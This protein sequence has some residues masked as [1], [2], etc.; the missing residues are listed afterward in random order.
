MID[1]GIFIGRDATA[2]RGME[3]AKSLSR[4]KSLGVTHALAASFRA[5]HFDAAEGNQDTM[6]AVQNSS[7]RL[8]PLAAVSTAAFEAGRGQIAG[9]KDQGF[10]GVILAPCLSG[11]R[12]AGYALRSL[13]SESAEAGLPLQVVIA[14]QA[15]LAEVA[16]RSATT[17]GPILVRWNRGG[18]YAQLPDVIAVG[19]DCPNLLFDIGIATQ[20]GSIELL[21][22]HLGPE[23]LF[24]AS[25]LPRAFEA[26]PYFML[27]AARLSDNSRRLIGGAN[28]ARIYG[29]PAPAESG[30]SAMFEALRTRPKIDTHWHTSGWNL[31]EPRIDDA[32][33]RQEFDYFS[34]K[35]VISS[36]IRA[37]NDDLRAGNAETL[38]LIESDARVRGLV[39][40]DP[41][42]PEVSITEIE[43]YRTDPRF[44]GVKTIQ[45][46]YHLD[47]DA[48]GY[49]RI[50]EH[51]RSLLDWPVMAH[52]PGMKEAATR[53]P[54]LHFI[55]A[56]STWDYRDL[57]LLSNV[58]FD[59]ATSTPLRDESDI[60]GLIEVVGAG[61][62]L[63]ST[64]GQLINPAWTL[65]KLASLDL[66][67]DD[68]D[69]IFLKNA[70]KAFPRLVQEARP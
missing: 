28:L 9:L 40:I 46:F 53:F 17:D 63:F 22:E 19:R 13:T 25:N 37:L 10:A 49:Q 60:A 66:S 64:D 15:E 65:G 4:L 27:Q 55:C 57:A 68:L 1:G 35:M 58:W 54:D 2:H 7:G 18:R 21:V 32:L 51:V 42:Q 62:V 43:R 50:F 33:L 26:C 61:R 41:L 34:Y 47:L 5:F 39:V 12:L 69:M 6:R 29:L 48:S 59:I 67:E 20:S 30:A 56:H 70:V 11:G 24:I 44:V 36:S 45:D 8:V 16:E 23:R 14:E 31:I 52:I 38:N 3:T